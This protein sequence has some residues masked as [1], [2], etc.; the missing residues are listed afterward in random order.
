MWAAVT[1]ALVRTM[2][3][4]ANVVLRPWQ[5][6]NEIFISEHSFAKLPFDSSSTT[7][8]IQI[9]VNGG[10][11]A[12]GLASCFSVGSGVAC[13]AVSAVIVTAVDQMYEVRRLHFVD[14]N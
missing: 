7:A 6:Y 9:S 2:V 1:G 3:Q 5:K 12:G 10:L 11:L 14:L 13:G 4:K 8:R